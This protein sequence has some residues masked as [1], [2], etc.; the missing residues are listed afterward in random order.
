MQPRVGVPFAEKKLIGR[1]CFAVCPDC[2]LEVRLS[3]RKD[4]ESWSNAEYAEHWT[5]EHG[6]RA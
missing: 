4:S 2:K 5:K 1:S 6:A 3:K